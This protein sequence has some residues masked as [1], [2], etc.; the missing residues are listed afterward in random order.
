MKKILFSIVALAFTT[1]VLA[2]TNA[3][4]RALI[5]ES[6]QYQ[7]KLQ[8]LSKASEIGEIRVGMAESGYLPVIS[9]NASYSYI[10][11]VGE[12][13][14]P[15]SAT[16]TRTIQFQPNNNYNVNVGLNQVIWDFGRTQAQ[17]EKAKVDLLVTKQ[18]TEAAK[19]QLATQVVNIYY[20]L[21]YLKKAVILQDSVIASYT[22]N[23]TLIENKLKQGDALKVDLSNID[24]TIHQELNRKVDFQR[25]YDRQQALL[26]Y[27]TG[28]TAEL[29]GVEFDFQFASTTEFSAVA[30]PD[31]IAADQRITASSADFKL[32]QR[33]RMPSLNFQASAGMRNG[34]Q[35]DIDEFRFNYLA[36]VTLSIP[37]FQG[38]RIRQNVSLAR[39]SMELSEISKQNLNATLLKDWQS[40]NADLCA[41][42]E[43][44]KNAM[45]QI[46]TAQEAQRLTQVRY[47]R[48]VATSVDLVFATTNLQ[49]SQLNQ[50]QYQYQ[51][52]LANAELARVEGRKFW[53]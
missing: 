18:N 11:P 45:I 10:D 2:Q 41:Y 32:A 4:L 22:K 51:A 1:H 6:F 30:N 8:E 33:N 17:I 13:K 21:V 43:Q 12:T 14:F 44:L 7:P 31:L 16:E 46:E 29:S 42:N 24:N 5:Q 40:A 25:Q 15:V 34:Y 48:G 3:E 36:G 52:C 28:R 35:P 53:E 50:L 39:K 38:G 20:S 27:T 49:R 47:D 19:L 26:Q 9:G 23:R 37:I